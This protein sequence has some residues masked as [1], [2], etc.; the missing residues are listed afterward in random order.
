[1]LRWRR[2]ARSLESFASWLR[3]PGQ[4][5]GGRRIWFPAAKGSPKPNAKHCVRLSRRR[6]L[7]ATTHIL[8]AVHF[9]GTPAGGGRFSVTLQAVAGKPNEV[10]LTEIP[11][12]AFVRFRSLGECYR[13]AVA[14][15]NDARARLSSATCAERDL[16]AQRERL[17][18][19]R[20][21]GM[22]LGGRLVAAVTSDEAIAEVDR[23]IAAA[24]AEIALM[25]RE[26]ERAEQRKSD[27][28]DLLSRCQGV[29]IDLGVPYSELRY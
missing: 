20:F 23:R 29:L 12:T 1:M 27:A 24:E 16:R 4:C 8:T 15:E 10:R 22:G 21:T 11:Q 17:T 14:V 5:V 7:L 28:G 25:G 26:V 6:R 13:A 19:Q 9:S 3:P 18:E 2:D